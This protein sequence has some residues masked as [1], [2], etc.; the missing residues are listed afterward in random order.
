MKIK[1]YLI[2]LIVERKTFKKYLTSSVLKMEKELFKLELEIKELRE[3][4]I[5]WEAFQK[6][7]DKK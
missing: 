5:K 2:G 3:R 1:E 4:K 6:M 7:L